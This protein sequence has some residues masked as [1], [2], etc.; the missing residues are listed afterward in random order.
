MRRAKGEEGVENLAKLV[1]RLSHRVKKKVIVLSSSPGDLLFV[2][3]TLRKNPINGTHPNLARCST[4]VGNGQIHGELYDL[5]TYPGV[6]L[7][8][9]CLDRVL[10][11]VY[12]LDS[13][14][15][16]RTWQ[17]LDHYEKC[18]PD[19]PEPHEYR[20]EK[21]HVFLDDGNEIDSWVYIL[22]SV[23]PVAVRVL[24]GDYLAWHRQKYDS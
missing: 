10:G 21:V 4:H 15:A 5:G 1:A 13:H 6:F 17:I 19:D 23:P 9:G 14:S 2:Y 11:E 7:R 8:E 3:G 12:A 18:A 20:R 24:G 16:L 22:T